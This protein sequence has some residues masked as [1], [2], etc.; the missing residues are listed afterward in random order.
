MT[1]AEITVFSV[2]LVSQSAIPG[3]RQSALACIPVCSTRFQGQEDN[4]EKDPPNRYRC[5]SEADDN[6]SC[7]FDKIERRDRD[8]Y[9]VQTRCKMEENG[10]YYPSPAEFQIINGLLFVKWVPE[11]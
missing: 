2:V 4:N 5:A 7:L 8:T 11:S 10:P 6:G 3:Y 1:L 9:L